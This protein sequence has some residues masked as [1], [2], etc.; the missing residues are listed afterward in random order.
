ML[1]VNCW[2]PSLTIRL[3]DP[4][5]HE[6]LQLYSSRLS[7][8]VFVGIESQR[9][10]TTRQ[11]GQSPRVRKSE[12]RSGGGTSYDDQR[13]STLLEEQPSRADVAPLRINWSLAGQPALPTL[14]RDSGGDQTGII[15]RA[16][17]CLQNGRDR[18]ALLS[19]RC[20]RGRP[21]IQIEPAR[22]WSDPF[23]KPTLMPV[24]E[25]ASHDRISCEVRHFHIH[26]TG[27]SRLIA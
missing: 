21:P 26:N 3:R 18:R 20:R 8:N 10:Q 19:V 14:S 2:I 5:S 6:F 22:T 16:A 17:Q 12:A 9:D 23:A 1:S 13:S 11:A 25:V 15:I 7:S 27:L 24:P 4:P